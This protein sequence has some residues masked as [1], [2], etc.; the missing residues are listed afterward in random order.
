MSSRCTACSANP[1]GW[2]GT[3]RPTSETRPSAAKASIAQKVVRSRRRSQSRTAITPS[4]M[5]ATR[6]TYSSMPARSRTG[7]LTK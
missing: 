3:A 7:P 4:V 1:L 6:L 2:V 5:N